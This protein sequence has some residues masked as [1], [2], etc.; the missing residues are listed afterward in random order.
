ME[1]VN[2]P[3][4]YSNRYQVTHLI[5]RGGMAL[6]YRAQDQMLNRPVALKILYPELSQDRNFVER[7]RREAQ[8]AANLS[9]P[10]IVPVYDWGEDDGTYFIVMELIEGK[11]LA[12][13]LRG[14]KKV[15]ATRAVQVVAQVAAAL[16]FAHRS[17]VVHRDVKPGNILLTADGQVKV[18]DF[19][20]AQA[21]A[22]KDHLAEEGSVMG[23]ATYFSPEQAEG[24][25]ADGR[26]DVYSLGVVLYEM[27]VG[28]PPFT[29]DSPLEVSTQHVN[30]K[31]PAP[32]VFNPK[33]PAELEAIVLM[34]LSKSP[35][36][37][38][39][40]AEELRTDLLRF[41]E[42]QPTRAAGSTSGAFS[43]SDS[44][45]AVGRVSSS[46]ERTQAVPIMTGPRTDIRRK[47]RM[48]SGQIMGAA[49]LVI[50][51]AALTYFFVGSAS[52]SSMPN[53]IGQQATQA[54]AT[55]KA[56][57]LIVTSTKLVTS[58]RPKGS[59]I[60]TNPSAGAHITKGESVSLK[61]SLGPS[62]A[63]VQVPNVLNLS[64]SDAESTLL[65]LG[66]SPRLAFTSIAPTANAV[67][68]TVLAQNPPAGSQA[69]T[70]DTIVITVLQ[71]GVNF[72]LPDIS[73]DT[74]L[75]A[76]T[77]LGQIGLTI[78]TATATQ[79]SNKIATGNV[80]ATIPPAGTSIKAGSAV[81]LI[82][83]SG[84]CQV[85]VPN[86]SSPMVS[87]NSALAT[88]HAQGFVVATPILTQTLLGCLNSGD[89]NTQSPAAGTLVPYGTTI[90]LTACP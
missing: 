38:Y 35:K 10:N 5:A 44:T 69:H 80:A 90:T 78:S 7:F 2:D 59:V 46:G 84:V 79:C 74:T 12:E 63:S 9:H 82:T 20:I 45:R 55:L 47:R 51:V 16:G 57:G 65:G 34:A 41:S 60:S 36:Q 73:G 85:T 4:L 81:E 77:A 31:A 68:D 67:P 39:Q 54:V 53:V 25:V 14:G 8:A 76:A 66:L 17:G 13:M 87:T 15:T 48:N 28:R 83:S 23:T 50:A 1:P 24:S 58:T 71:P 89:I 52:S 30:A 49:A 70:G 32:S 86:V 61:V 18:T 22:S 37:R 88:L 21:V 19:G 56:D 42:G 11:T 3:R 72:P 43:G 26:S 33:V 6:V 40:T 64:V 29:G 75:A 27:L 62:T